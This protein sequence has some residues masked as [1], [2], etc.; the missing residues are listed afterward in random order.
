MPFLAKE[1]HP[2]PTKDLLS[3][4][5]DGLAYDWDDP[6][7]QRRSSIKRLSESLS[8][9]SY[10][11]IAFANH[12]DQAFISVGGVGHYVAFLSSYHSFPKQF[13]PYKSSRWKWTTTRQKE[14]AAYPPTLPS[15]ITLPHH[16]PTTN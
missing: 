2:V 5:F 8:S 15:H 13:L 3:W 12:R 11:G 4:T 10:T 9:L 1:H 16:P 7:S 6:V 14:D